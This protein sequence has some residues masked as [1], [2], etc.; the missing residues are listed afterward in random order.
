MHDSDAFVDDF[1]DEVFA[2]PLSFPPGDPFSAP[3]WYVGVGRRSQ[4]ELSFLVRCRD[5]FFGQDCNTECIDNQR[6]FCNS[7]GSRTCNQGYFNLPECLTEC[8]PTGNSFCDTMGNKVCR[9]NYFNKNCSAFCGESQSE[10]TGFYTCNPLT[11]ERE[12]LSGYGPATNCTE[13]AQTTYAC[14]FI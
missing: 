2:Q 1:V 4:I 3:T 8:T 7:D 13:L 5:N 6:F 12:C 11:G 14:E 9:E 10:D